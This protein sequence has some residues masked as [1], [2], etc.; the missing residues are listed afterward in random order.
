MDSHIPRQKPPLSL[1]EARRKAESF[2]A[3]QERSQQELRDKLYSWGLHRQ[4][5][6]QLIAEMIAENF[7]NEERFAMAYARGK[8]Q[9]KG[10]GKK[11][12][13]QGLKAKAVSAR[14]VA[15]ALA[16]LEKD[17]YEER[18]ESL[19]RKKASLLKDTDPYVRKMKLARYA[20]GKGYE[21]DAIFLFLNA[22]N[23]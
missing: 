4:E 7:L 10:W 22:N 9:L 21:N 8:F 2:C 20:M 6:E 18:L 11:K 17:D 19:L 1:Q 15:Q 14:L 23:L 3:Y 12:I 5:V 13:E 16:S